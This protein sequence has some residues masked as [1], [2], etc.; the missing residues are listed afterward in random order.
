MEMQCTTRMRKSVSS[1]HRETLQSSQGEVL[2]SLR[3]LWAQEI[4]SPRRSL[5]VTSILGMA[6]EPTPQDSSFKTTR[7]RS[8]E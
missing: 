3:W 7:L 4:T 2:T 6:S 1:S 8:G 5:P